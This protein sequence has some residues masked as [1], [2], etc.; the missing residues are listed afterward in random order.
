MKQR[1]N[2]QTVSRYVV[3]DSFDDLEKGLVLF[4]AMTAAVLDSCIPKAVEMTHSTF[5]SGDAITVNLLHRPTVY[6]VGQLLSSYASYQLGHEV[7]MP[8]IVQLSGDFSF[9]SD[10]S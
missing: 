4:A 9:A 3:A 8:I 5:T 1:Q 10:C 7:T 6:H 2:D